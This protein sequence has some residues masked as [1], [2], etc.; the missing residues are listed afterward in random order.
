AALKVH[1]GAE[2]TKGSDLGR[3]AAVGATILVS[4]I[5][6]SVLLVGSCVYRNQHPDSG[7]AAIKRGMTWREVRELLGSPSWDSTCFNP[8]Y[9]IYG[10]PKADCVRELGY[11]GGF[12]GFPAGNYCLIW[13]DED[14]KVIDTTSITSP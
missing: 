11:Y 8:K 13:L 1:G 3:S 7:L 10:R 12:F 14:D 2:V 9:N 4:V 5:L 6:T